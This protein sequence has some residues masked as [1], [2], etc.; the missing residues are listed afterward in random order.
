MSARLGLSLVL[1]VAACGDDGTGTPDA[2][3]AILP[4]ANPARELLDTK[5]AYDVTALTATATI[6]FGPSAEPGGTLEVGD[7]MIDS[8]TL[9][10]ADV[11][12]TAATAPGAMLHA[13]DH[14]IDL[15]L[16]WSETPLVVTIAFHYKF[17]GSF[18]GAAAAGYTLVWPYHCGNLFPC[19]SRPDDGLTMSLALT[20]V[21]A[22]KTAVFPPTLTEAPSYQIA[23]S[24]ESY[25]ELPLGTTTAGT[26]VSMWYRP[27]EMAAAMTGGANLVAVFDWYEKTIGPYRFGNKVGTVSVKWCPGALGGMEHHPMWHVSS[28]AIGDEETNAHEAAHG[29]FGDGIRIACWEDF[30]LSE[31]TVT[32]LAGRA[33]EVVAP[34]VGAAVWSSYATELNGVPATDKVWPQSCNAIDIIDDDLFTNAPYMRGAFFY[35]GV[36]LKVG[37]PLLDQ[38]LAAFYAAHA[39]KAAHMSEMLDTIKTVTGYDPTACADMWLKST[40]KPAAG[41]VCP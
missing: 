31:G 40:T 38:A 11:A 6:T 8:V 30:V 24:I 17:H 28:S 26:A 18:E 23:W 1:L 22:G 37:A 32:Y 19:H 27:T 3:V 21:P 20:G 15:A 5:L 13:N 41:S 14:T 39:G 12:F 4:T 16:P 7:L 10:G 34:T 25:T 29:W 33:L 36:A 9:D 2:P 35:R